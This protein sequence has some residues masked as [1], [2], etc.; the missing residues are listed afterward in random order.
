M[1]PFMLKWKRYLAAIVQSCLEKWAE[2]E[3]LEKI[4]EALHIPHSRTVHRWIRPIA[5]C[6]HRISGALRQLM[7]DE[8]EQKGV[9]ETETQFDGRR[10]IQQ[11]LE[12]VNRLKD[13]ISLNS[14]DRLR[15]AYHFV[16]CAA[17]SI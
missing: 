16:L 11:L 3:S 1:P 14:I 6:V 9:N 4:A 10:A 8:D 13:H 15:T 2:G 5:A 17:R 12:I 7:D